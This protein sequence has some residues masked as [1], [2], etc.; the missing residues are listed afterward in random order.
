MFLSL[1]FARLHWREK[2]F[3]FWVGLRG[4]VPIAPT[5]FPLLPGMTGSEAIFNIVFFTVL[6]SA[7]T[8]RLVDSRRCPSDETAPRQSHCTCK[9]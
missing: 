6:T 7:L 2:V 5:T 1:P 3:V 4:S 8:P 9:P